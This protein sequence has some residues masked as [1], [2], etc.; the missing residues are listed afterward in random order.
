MKA[1]MV[2]LS[3]VW[4]ERLSFEDLRARIAVRLDVSLDSRSGR[5]PRPGRHSG[6]H[7]AGTGLPRLLSASDEAARGTQMQESDDPH[8]PVWRIFPYINAMH[9]RCD[10]SWEREWRCRRSLRFKESDLVCLILPEEGEEDIKRSGFES[11]DCRDLARMD[12]RADRRRTLKT[13]ARHEENPCHWKCGWPKGN[14]GRCN[15]AGQTQSLIRK[16]SRGRQS[17]T[18]YAQL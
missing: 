13:T 8:D 12:L 16:A 10:F 11:R 6:I 14:R 4:R 3:W 9:E 1:A 15:F 5:L 18:D 7:D 2:T 17:M